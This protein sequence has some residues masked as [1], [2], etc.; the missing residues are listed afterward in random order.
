MSPIRKKKLEVIRKKLDKLDNSLLS[1][2]KKRTLLVNEVVKLKKFK[3]E[4]VDKKRIRVILTKI[5]KKSIQKKID[6][7]ITNRIWKNMIWSYINY[8]RKNFNKK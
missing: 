8:E 5:R 2:I 3:K 7:N 4:I 6:P 1:I